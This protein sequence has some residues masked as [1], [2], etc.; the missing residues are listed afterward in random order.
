MIGVRDRALA[1]IPEPERHMWQAFWQEVEGLLGG[2]AAG[3]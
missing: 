2:P 3:R 1:D